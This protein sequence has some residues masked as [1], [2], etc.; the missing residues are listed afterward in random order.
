MAL[1]SLQNAWPNQRSGLRPRGLQS[2]D[3]G[4][5]RLSVAGSIP[6]AIMM[7]S[8]EQ[9]P[10]QRGEATSRTG[11]GAGQGDR[12]RAV[13]SIAVLILGLWTIRHGDGGGAIRLGRREGPSSATEA[14]GPSATA[15]GGASATMPLASCR[16]TASV[17]WSAHPAMET[18]ARKNSSVAA[19]ADT[20]AAN[21]AKV[22]PADDSGA[23]AALISS[24]SAT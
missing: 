21:L 4:T 9:A 11:F 12:V 1:M 2:F 24:R 20:A 15:A 8:N 7:S 14:E 6:Q 5:D 10:S 3:T 22:P 19:G 23:S 13:G 16:E 18:P 17:R